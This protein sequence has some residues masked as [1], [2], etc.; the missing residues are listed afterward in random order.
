VGLVLL[1]RRWERR[2]E[3]RAYGAG[4]V[5]AAAIYVLFGI[6]H[7]APAEHLALDGVGVALFGT[8]AVAGLRN[9]PL[10]LAAGWTSHVAWD[11]FVHHANGTPWAPDWYP[12]LCVGFDLFL[13][14][15]LA[16]IVGKERYNFDP[17]SP[18]ASEILEQAL[19]LDER[20]RATVAGALIESLEGPGDSG[21][22]E[23]WST[24][25]R[26]RVAELEAGAVATVPWS[27]V[28]ERLFRGYE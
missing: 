19:E 23:A 1:A 26:R 5:V 25:I 21:A 7:G 9:R 28:R 3:L 4:L 24:E 8:I 20:D 10:L 12:L 13:G 16:G 27:E 2:A 11:L 18:K 17:M 22:E 15:Y 14:G 6:A